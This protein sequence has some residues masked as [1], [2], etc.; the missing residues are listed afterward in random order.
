MVPWPAC[1]CLQ[2]FLDNSHLAVVNH[3]HKEVYE[4]NPAFGAKETNRRDKVC[5]ALFL[6]NPLELVTRPELNQNPPALARRTS[7]CPNKLAKT[8]LDFSGL[9]I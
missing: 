9:I 1:S 7:V 6:A 2:F 4:W 8:A 3:I 5:L